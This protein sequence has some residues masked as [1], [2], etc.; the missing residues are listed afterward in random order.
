MVAG[1]K[2]DLLR[3]VDS[4]DTY[5]PTGT[6][7][8]PGSLWGTHA[9]SSQ[10]HSM[11]NG[12]DGPT[13]NVK[14]DQR[15]VPKRDRASSHSSTGSSS[16][17]KSDGL[18]SPFKPAEMMPPST[19]KQSDSFGYTPPVP[20]YAISPVDSIPRGYIAH[21]R[22]ACVDIDYQWDSMRE[23][24]LWGDG[25]T[26]GEEWS[27]MHKR[28]RRGLESMLE[29]YGENHGN[30][31]TDDHEA[32]PGVSPNGEEEEDEETE[33]VLVLVTH[34]AGCNALI[35]AMTNQPVLLDV[36]MASLTMATRKPDAPSLLGTTASP[37]RVPVPVTTDSDP[38][39]HPPHRRSS[40]D[41]GLSSVYDMKI[42]ASS[43]HLRPGVDPSNTSAPAPLSPFLSS[44]NAPD[45]RRRY[46]SGSHAAA[47]APIASSWDLGEPAHQ[48]PPRP[49]HPALGSMRRP[50]QATGIQPI[51]PYSISTAPPPQPRPI[52]ANIDGSSAASGLWSPMGGKPDSPSNLTSDV[53]Y[54]LDGATKSTDDIASPKQTDGASTPEE[55][56][57]K[58]A[59]EAEKDEA[60]SD[61]PIV[62]SEIP[63][64]L[65]RSLSQRG[66][67]GS[68][69]SGARNERVQ[70]ITKRRWTLQQER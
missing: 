35:G 1:A 5:A 42:V 52:S 10:P 43:E 25:G 50:S 7:K 33:L 46:G 51:R 20:T 6:P 66:L 40:V 70:G 2:A 62:S 16:S 69:P 36:G 28:F 48:P 24:H 67:W 59:E 38:R 26:F 15:A 68:A 17:H 12:S 30:Q 31:H 29:W 56:A 39:P 58:L 18:S 55:V 65:G 60:V 61:L 34:G 11:S 27:S 21:A 14:T 4:I 3:Q 45:Y 53:P 63:K 13:D 22:E 9:A 57:E 64:G 37:T 54:S 19:S 47:G 32:V 49:N 23:P 41:L 44:Q 8:L